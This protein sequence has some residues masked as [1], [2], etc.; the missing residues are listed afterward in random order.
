MPNFV[1]MQNLV[2][3]KRG[4]K[5]SV[6]LYLHRH[7]GDLHRHVQGGAAAGQHSAGIPGL[8]RM[9]VTR[10]ALTSGLHQL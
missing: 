1:R 3:F 10:E 9:E 7:V 5:T 2:N 4:V 8:G 6:H